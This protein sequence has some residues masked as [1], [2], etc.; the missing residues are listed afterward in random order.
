MY[1]AALR[2]GS[3]ALINPMPFP[4][5]GGLLEREPAACAQHRVALHSYTLRRH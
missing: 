1:S 2:S 5:K 3:R 4:G